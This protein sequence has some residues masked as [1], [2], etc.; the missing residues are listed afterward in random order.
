L[1]DCN[2]PASLHCPLRP[3]LHFAGCV[4]PARFASTCK[5]IPPQCRRE[6]TPV[7][8][9]PKWGL[10]GTIE[11]LQGLQLRRLRRW[12]LACTSF[13][14]WAATRLYD[15]I[16]HVG[17]SRSTSISLRVGW[18]RRQRPPKITSGELRLCPL[19]GASE[20]PALVSSLNRVSNPIPRS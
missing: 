3:F 10:R 11:M 4:I 5:E 1:L 15:S 18:T 17:S 7:R 20:F 12:H 13:G 2:T 19:P 16:L 8:S 9:R 14:G 6:T